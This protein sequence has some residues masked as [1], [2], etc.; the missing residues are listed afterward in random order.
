M[1]SFLF[2]PPQSH[3]LPPSSFASIKVVVLN[4]PTHS[5]L[6]LLPSPYAGASN[7]HR[8]KGLPSHCCQIRPCSATYIVRAIDP[9]AG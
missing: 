4:P 3:I 2:P 1:S 8:T 5:H 9:S 6:T 7:L